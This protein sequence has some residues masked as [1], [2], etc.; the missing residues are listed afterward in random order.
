MNNLQATKPKNSETTEL[1]QKK[2]RG[3]PPEFLFKKGQSGNPKGR[4]EGTFSLLT[5]L[6]QELQ[7]VPEGQDKKT[8]AD[9]IVKRMLKQAIEKGDQQQIKLIWN[10][11][12]GMPRQ[13]LNVD[14]KTQ[15]IEEVVEAT[16]KLLDE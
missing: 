5:L 8:Y 2:R 14:V 10:Y 11:I 6:K 15:K 3:A 1:K 13:D 16:K 9:L 4:P 7:K 12:E